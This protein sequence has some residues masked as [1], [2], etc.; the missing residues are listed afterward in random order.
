MN[1]KKWTS[2]LCAAAL[3]LSLAAC[4]AQTAGTSESQGTLTGQVTEVDGSQVTLLLGTLNENENGSGT[5]PDGTP[6]GD[7]GQ[8]GQAGTPPEKPAGSTHSGSTNSQ[9]PAKPDGG[10][11]SSGGTPPEMPSGG[12][13]SGAAPSG[14]APQGEPPARPG[15]SFTAGNGSVTLDFSKAEI[16]ENGE[17]VGLEDIEVGDVLT[18]AAAPPTP[19]A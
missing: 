6:D 8:G 15:S 16:T 19:A 7:P 1:A 10:S 3:T 2:I 5:A 18:V 12:Q 11:T 17:N 14:N 9:P 4:G 13:P